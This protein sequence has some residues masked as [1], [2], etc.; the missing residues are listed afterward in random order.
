MS[1]WFTDCGMS[2]SI[3][4]Y[5]YNNPTPSLWSNLRSKT[6]KQSWSQSAI[7]TDSWVR[8]NWTRK[9]RIFGEST[10]W[11]KHR[12]RKYSKKSNRESDVI[13]DPIQ[14]FSIY[15]HIIFILY[16]NCLDFFFL[17]VNHFALTSPSPS[18]SYLQ[19]FLS[20]LPDLFLLF[21]L[22][23]HILNL[24]YSFSFLHLFYWPTF[25]YFCFRLLFILV[26]LPFI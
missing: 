19:S 16:K 23:I 11:T 25:L 7:K 24:F 8:V 2:H 15:R 9:W 6:N 5:R 10:E 12:R 20:L 14:F 4:R 21:L 26:F 13:N 17:R 3:L 1:G 18:L 22:L